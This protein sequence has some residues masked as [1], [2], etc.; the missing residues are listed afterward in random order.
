MPRAARYLGPRGLRPPHHAQSTETAYSF[1]KNHT[2]IH[3]HPYIQS[4][5]Y[6][7]TPYLLHRPVGPL[8]DSL[9]AV[10]V[11]HPIIK[12]LGRPLQHRVINLEDSALKV[13]VRSVE[14]FEV[15]ASLAGQDIHGPFAGDE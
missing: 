15:P 5:I 9:M 8:L 11:P 10:R 1:H 12:C 3:I 4:Q 14:D 6:T 7:Y 13:L 2:N